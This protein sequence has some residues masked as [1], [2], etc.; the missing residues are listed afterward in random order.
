MS[1]YTL[2]RN[3]FCASAGLH[4]LVEICLLAMEK[5]QIM[6]WMGMEPL[7][8]SPEF[9]QNEADLTAYDQFREF[10]SFL[11]GLGGLS[12]EWF[13]YFNGRELTYNIPNP[14]VWDVAQNSSSAANDGPSSEPSRPMEERLE[15]PVGSWLPPAPRAG[16]I[17]EDFPEDRHGNTV[18]ATSRIS[19]EQHAQII[20]AL[21][22]F[23]DV[24][25]PNFKLPSRHALTRYVTACFEGFIRNLPFI[26]HT[27][28]VIET[29]MELL[30]AICAIGAVH[31]FENRISRQLYEAAKAI[32]MARILREQDRFGPGTAD[33]L[34]FHKHG[35]DDRVMEDRVLTTGVSELDWGS[36]EPIDTV[37]TLILLTGYAAWAQKVWFVQDALRLQRLLAQIL[38]DLGLQDDEESVPASI[39]RR[40]ATAWH[41]WVRKE[42]NRRAKLSAFAFIHTASIAYNVYP[43][44]RTSEIFLRLP[45]TTR[46]W[47]ALTV[48]QWHAARQTVSI[49]QLYL[50]DALRLL[51]TKSSR[52]TMLD[53][54]PAPL[55][56]Y[57]LLHGLIQRIY[58]MR[59][60]LLPL[61]NQTSLPREE[62]ETLERALH[63]WA[64]GFRLAPESSLDQQND[65]G[66]IP[67]TC[68][69][70]LALA[71]IRIYQNLGPHRQLDSRDP[72]QIAA[73]LSRCPPV[74]RDDNIISAVLYATHALSIPVRLGLDRVAR[75]QFFFWTVRHSLS[76]LECAVFLSQWLSALA[77]TIDSAP[78]TDAEFHILQWLRRVVEEAYA[79]V[80]FD[81]GDFE[82]HGDPAFLSLAVLKVW[83][84][85][86]KKNAQW[87][88]IN[89]LGESLEKY[90]GMRVIA[91][92]LPVPANRINDK[93]VWR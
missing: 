41:D 64:S 61:V 25:G 55:G 8:L 53:P 44:V 62:A 80:D 81:D 45:C 5:W 83:A 70:M 30:L 17:V 36:W 31:C 59:D 54:L 87:P 84:H 49:E 57:I 91:Q 23:R 90:H 77:C 32:L 48:S 24:I 67:F 14:Q 73:A 4:S 7:D 35:T 38:R 66:P 28:R 1:E 2:K 15:T 33:F 65:H 40:T 10:G 69:A 92:G 34:H 29:A 12:A 88:F 19:D 82:F 85:F 89:V 18:P 75:S 42:S 79:F 60:L 43:V 56:N 27:W 11:D 78:L 63:S 71:Y 22:A 21:E 37:P 13:S 46:E 68:S 6:Q 3:P 58:L 20:F 26:H 93:E 51:L 16:R 39:E 72:V 86:F 76:G 9:L 52:P 47:N 50:Q 74:T